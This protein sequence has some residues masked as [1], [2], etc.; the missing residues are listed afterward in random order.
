MV[1]KFFFFSDR[2][3]NPINPLPLTNSTMHSTK[4]NREGLK[5]RE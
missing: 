5:V 3:E 1:E 4:I 2:C